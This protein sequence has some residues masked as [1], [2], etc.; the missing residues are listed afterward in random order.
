MALFD[1]KMHDPVQATA[2]VVDN[3][4][5]ASIPGQAI[6][7]P[8]DLMVEGDGLPAYMVHI[9]VRPKTGKWPEINQVL[10][11][12]VDRSNPTRVEILWDQIPSLQERVQ[13][14][15]AA[16]LEAA[17]QAIAKSQ[18]DRIRGE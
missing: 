1:K 9:K 14:R 13:L 11:V 18:Q 2:R 10:P 17:Q 6:H 3:N 15:T 5:L 4:G 8:L 12:V 7:C 16:R